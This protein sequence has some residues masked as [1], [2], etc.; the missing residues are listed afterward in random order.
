MLTRTTP[1]A[2][3]SAIPEKQ[4]DDD[5]AMKGRLRRNLAAHERGT[6]A[7]LGEGWQQ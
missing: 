7:G 4:L 5:L 1:L 6:R 3:Q 2:A